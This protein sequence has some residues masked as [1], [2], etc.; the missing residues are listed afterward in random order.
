MAPSP[1]LAVFVYG[2]LLD[3]AALDTCFDDVEQRVWPVRGQGFERV[4]NQRASWRATDGTQ[5]GVLNVVRADGAWCNGLLVTDIQREEFQAF[6][7]RE[8]GYR[9]VELPATDIEP[10]AARNV[11]TTHIDT[12]VPP[13]DEHDLVLTTT[14]TKVDHDI[15]PIPSYL[16][17]CLEGA[18]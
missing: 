18:S 5:Q 14:G 16:D 3:P 6:S 11:D 8:A 2:S 13:I 4:C 1:R 12:T 17:E 10:Y 15:D 9:L 7:D